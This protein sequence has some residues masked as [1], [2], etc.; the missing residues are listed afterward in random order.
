MASLYHYRCCAYGVAERYAEHQCVRCQRRLCF[1]C[2]YLG[3]S[4]R[5]A[6]VPEEALSEPDS[7]V[8]EAE[9]TLVDISFI[10]RRLLRLPS[11]T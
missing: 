11:G 1:H 9:W 5:R 8:N 3:H 7:S 2:S 10:E 6:P 4:C